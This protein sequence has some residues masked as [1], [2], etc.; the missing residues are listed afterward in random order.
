MSNWDTVLS[1]M[2]VAPDDKFLEP[3]FHPQIKKCKSIS[4]DI[5]IYERATGGA[6]ERSYAYLYQAASNYLARRRLDRN[7]ER[8][9]RQLG[10]DSPHSLRPNVSLKA[11]AFRS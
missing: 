9:A 4:H 1:G 11:F 8:M 10:D 6:K 7:R 3:L 2:K 5:A